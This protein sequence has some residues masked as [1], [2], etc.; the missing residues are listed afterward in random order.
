MIRNSPLAAITASAMTAF[1][2]LNNVA[3]PTTAFVMPSP[4]SSSTSIANT[5]TRGMPL[6]SMVEENM[7]KEMLEMKNSLEE[8]NGTSEMPKQDANG[9]YDLN[10]KEDHLALL[11]AHPGKIIIMKFYAPWCRACKGLEPKFIQISKDTKY[12]KLPLLFAQMSVQHNK[13][14]I[15]SIGILALPSVHIYSGTEGLVENF[16]CGPSKLPVLKKK[17]AQVVNSKV[18]ATTLELKTVTVTVAESEP[19]AEREVSNTTGTNTELSVGDVV[20]SVVT[21][22]DLKEIP[23][24]KDLSDTGF[25]DLMA[26]AKYATFEAG[27]VIMRQGLPG[28]TFY[29]IDSG[30]VEISVKGPFEDPLTTPSGYLGTTINRFSKGDYFGERSLITGQPR[31]ASIRAIEKTRCF[32]FDVDVIPDTSV[33]SGKGHATDDRIGQ[34]NEKYGVDFYDIDLLNSQM[35]A[36]NMANQSRGSV[37]RPESI[38]GVDTEAD[39]IV[40]IDDNILSLLVRFKLLRNAARCFEYIKETNPRW[41]DVGETYRRSLLVS[42]LTSTQRQEF[43]ELFQLIDTSGDNKISVMELKKVLE[44]IEDTGRS[45]AELEEMINKSNPTVDGNK[46]MTYSDFM[47]V[48]AEAEFYYLF[49]DTFSTLDT[50]NSGYV[51]AGKIEKVLGGLRDLISDD[52]K[53]IIDMDDKDLLVDYETF[54]R[55]MIGAH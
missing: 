22:N 18:D 42:K 25:S 40:D 30:E 43:T 48:M 38:T 29:F 3:Q 55:M 9:I 28:R 19:C 34:V 32:T 36:A 1:L 54:S 4:P 37:N 33:L 23:F 51:Q 2:I 21:M 46:E 26:K 50:D 5:F 44:T 20:V 12:D 27:S 8:K 49:K 31:A 39:P 14:Y 7:E 13:A 41:G 16:P 6:Q 10:T 35:D 15:K 17:I 53:S 45:D 47:G 24:F 11:A 52:R